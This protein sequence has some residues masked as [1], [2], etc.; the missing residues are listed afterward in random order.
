MHSYI[1]PKLDRRSALVEGANLTRSVRTLTDVAYCAYEV[2]KRK[3]VNY[4]LGV[5]F[6]LKETICWVSYLKAIF[7]HDILAQELTPFLTETTLLIIRFCFS[8]FGKSSN[9]IQVNFLE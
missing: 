2:P 9:H 7:P 5:L 8:P 6:H 1:V 4:N 3:E